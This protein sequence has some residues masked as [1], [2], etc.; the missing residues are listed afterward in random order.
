MLKTIFFTVITLTSMP[1]MAGPAINVGELNEYIQPEKSTLAKRINNTGDATAFVRVSVDEMIF[2]DRGY[3]E[4]RLDTSALIKGTGTGLISSPA[5]LII[6]AKGMQTNRLVFTG[7]R[8]NERYYRVRYIPVIPQDAQEFGL[9]KDDAKKYQDEI[10]AGVTVLTG[11]GTIV[12]VLPS[13]ARFNTR[14]TED[15]R[16]LKISNNGN[17]SIVIQ[18]L[19]ECDKNLKNCTNV[20][21]HQLRPGMKLEKPV[22]TGKVWQYV[23]HEGMQNKSL[24]SG[25]PL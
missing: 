8:D 13:S 4:N 2:T 3:T 25:K 19:K 9:S 22:T 15:S 18:S 7:S 21:T 17:A 24:T 10:S 5:R 14:I 6:P 16:T 1:A 12:T 23:L 11:F 20:T